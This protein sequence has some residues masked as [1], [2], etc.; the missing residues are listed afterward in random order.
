[1]GTKENMLMIISEPL[2][3]P[4]RSGARCRRIRA[5]SIGEDFDLVARLHR[6]LVDV[7]ETI[8]SSLFPIPFAGRKYHRTFDRSLDK[9]RVGRRVF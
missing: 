5:S 8:T 1:M 7:K 2:G 4:N 6:R 9:E 3:V